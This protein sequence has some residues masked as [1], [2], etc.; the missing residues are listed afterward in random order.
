MLCQSNCSNRGESAPCH[1]L[2]YVQLDLGAIC[3]KIRLPLIQTV[4]VSRAS[5]RGSV[6]LKQPKGYELYCRIEM[7]IFKVKLN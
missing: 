6:V 1:L 4:V 3:C 2:C 7:V 5:D